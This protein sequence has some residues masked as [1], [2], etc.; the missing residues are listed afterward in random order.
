MLLRATLRE[1]PQC[2]L[3]RVGDALLQQQTRY[4]HPRATLPA[5]AMDGDHV[6]GVLDQPRVA[7]VHNHEKLVCPSTPNT[8]LTQ[9]TR[10]VVLDAVPRVATAKALDRRLGVPRLRTQIQTGGEKK[11]WDIHPIMAHMGTIQVPLHVVHIVSPH[12]LPTIAWPRHRNDPL[13]SWNSTT[14]PYS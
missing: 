1:V 13:Y 9:R 7:L 6:R 14:T 10:V 2:R 3:R 5:L 12:R 4:H 8:T 11:K